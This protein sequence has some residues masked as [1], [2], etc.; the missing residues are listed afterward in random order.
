MVPLLIKKM[1]KKMGS[2]YR[3]IAVGV[4][5]LAYSCSS[6]SRF[7]WSPLIPAA[8]GELGFSMT[9]AGNLMSA[10]YFGYL[11]T[12]LP[13]GFLADKFRVKGMMF[14]SVSLVAVMTF[15]MSG[16]QS[17][18]QA[19]IVRFFAG[20]CGG[21]IMAF[22][23]RILSNDFLPSE[24]GLAFGIMLSGAS[25]GT[26]LANQ[27]GPRFLVAMGWRTAFRASAFVIAIIAVLVL[28][29]VREH[30]TRAVVTPENKTG[31]LD[32]LK[33]YFTNPQILIISVVGFLYMAAVAG[34]STWSNKFITGVAPG[35]GGLTPAQAGTIIT[36]YSI[37]S[38]LGSASSG[39]I[40]K[41]LKINPKTFIIAV[42]LLIAVFMVVFAMQ[43]TFA[44]LL[45]TSAVLGIVSCMSGTHLAAW[46]VNL[47]GSKHAATTTALQNL[48]FQSSNV[49]FPTLT[50]A[51]IDRATVDGAVT[52]YMGVWGLFSTLLVASALIAMTASGKSAVAKEM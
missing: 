10:F 23:A 9:Q 13:A 48:S 49:I 5:A 18:G 14:I 34:Y 44:G 50:G 35:G 51:V 36:V 1:V 38:I 30:K 15:G 24:R 12:Q 11:V 42:H 29:F 32:G 31:L 33:N 21:F 25:I 4:L 41:S 52:S 20:L 8:S 40:A 3:W 39:F 2:R 16:I 46:A 28:I 47:G 26:L 19:L 27:V 22:C 17:Y 43:T 6:F 7:V 45:G 37:L